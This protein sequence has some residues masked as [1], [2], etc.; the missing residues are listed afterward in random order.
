M[1]RIPF[2][3]GRRTS[4]RIATDF[5]LFSARPLPETAVPAY[6][7]GYER[8]AWRLA[9][10]RADYFAWEPLA[11]G[12][13]F[14]DAIVEAEIEADPANGHSAAGLLFRRASD[15]NYYCL[16]VGSLGTWRFDVV[17]NNH[18]MPLVGWTPM[19]EPSGPT[20]LLRVVA[21]GTRFIVT[22]DGEWVGEV[23]DETLAG[24]AV[25]VAA[26]N[27]HERDTATFRLHRIEVD[28]RPVEVE[29]EYLRLSYHFPVQPGAR[30]ALAETLFAQGGHGAAAVQLRKALRD[31]E[32]T[33]RE[34]FLLAEC[35]AR[36]GANPLALEELDRVLAA[37]PAHHEAR[38][39]RAGV[40]YLANRFLEARDASAALLADPAYTPRS[41]AWNLLGNAEYALG[42]W[43][44]A[45]D[46]Y[47]RAVE[48]E[49]GMPLLLRNAARALEMAGDRDGALKRYLEAAGRL[50]VEDANDELALI[51]ARVQALDPSNRAVR[52]LAARALYRE[53]KRDEA[54]R[55]LSALAGAGSEDPDVHYLLG[56]I[57]TETGDRAGAL[58]C[59]ERAAALAP[60]VAA[61]QLRLAETLHLLGRDPGSALERARAL[62]PGDPWL[63][64]LEGLRLMAGGDAVAAAERF[65]T[66]LAAAPREVDIRLNLSEALSRAGRADE[67]LAAVAG[68][69]DHRLV[70]QRGTLHARAGRHDEAVRDYEAAI[71]ADPANRAYRE[72]CAAS[73]LEVDLVSRAEELL[74]GLAREKPTASVYNLLGNVAGMRGE[75]QRAELAW[76]AGLALE[77]GNPDIRANLA[78]LHLDRGN[79]QRSRELVDETLAIEAG[80]EHARRLDE[81]IHEVY[82]RRY[83]CDGCGRAWWAPRDLPPQPGFRAR[84]EPPGDAP[85]GRCGECGK[86]YCVACASAHVVDGRL[87]C[88]ACGGRL[89]LS[90]DALRWLFA[91]SVERERRP[92]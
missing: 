3:K 50:A 54:R 45:A 69:E 57:A 20:R 91:R 63:A 87:T 80:H 30:L 61:H 49:P 17:F 31:R 70:N 46:A 43:R 28:A 21:R 1:L 82:E 8:G 66:A 40:L 52:A 42:N 39:A 55:E 73:C 77:P 12:R 33:P 60:D 68:E 92:D 65:A 14:V 36:L 78:A 86:L 29:R 38:L 58:P 79:W 13:A 2:L 4:S 7:A 37:D 64:N 81:R 84:G 75:R 6:E 25:C 15:E 5:G 16:L 88:A 26:Q 76:A 56:L 71:R 22:V 24:G 48:L 47:L 44:K 72:N 32:G 27:Y 9:V 85:A 83:D 67:A 41:D 35:Y 10:R 62:A 11:G 53:G 19:P 59:F 18:Q 74:A 89:K 23:E 34:R 90:D 51:T